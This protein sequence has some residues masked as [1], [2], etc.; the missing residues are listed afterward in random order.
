M[1]LDFSLTIPFADIVFTHF[2]IQQH[3]LQ[4]PAAH[5]MLGR[6]VSSYRTPI[7]TSPA[8][9]PGLGGIALRKV[10]RMVVMYLMCMPPWVGVGGCG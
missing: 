2:H 7:S 6:A 3:L 1:N 9:G 4:H 10:G 5:R 8:A